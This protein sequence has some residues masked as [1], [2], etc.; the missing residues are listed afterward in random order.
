[1]VSWILNKNRHAFPSTGEFHAT[2]NLKSQL[3]I[4]GESVIV[5]P[6]SNVQIRLIKLH[7][8]IQLTLLTKDS[9]SSCRGILVFILG[10]QRVCFLF[11][12]LAHADF[13][14]AIIA[15]DKAIASR[16]G[17]LDQ[18]NFIRGGTLVL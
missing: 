1:M 3:T 6:V 17:K 18:S 5:F 2:L 10:Q 9:Q 15:H 7:K 11:F 8:V 14:H 16:S 13:S 4:F 12:F